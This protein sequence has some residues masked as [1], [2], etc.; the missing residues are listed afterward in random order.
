MDISKYR[1]KSYTIWLVGILILALLI[2]MPF[3]SWFM[4]GLQILLWIFYVMLSIIYVLAYVGTFYYD[5]DE[6]GSPV[7]K[8]RVFSVKPYDHITG[9]ITI[10]M[11]GYVFNEHLMAAGAICIALGALLLYRIKKLYFEKDVQKSS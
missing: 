2:V 11:V 5:I 6:I 1:K 3:P 8:T 9:V 4:A 10:S 7:S